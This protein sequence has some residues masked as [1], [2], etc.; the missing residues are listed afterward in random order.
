MFLSFNANVLEGKADGPFYTMKDLAEF[1]LHL[2]NAGTLPPYVEGG[3]S[4]LDAKMMRNLR[5][6]LKKMVRNVKTDKSYFDSSNTKFGMFL[7]E[8]S[9]PVF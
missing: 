3:L 8:A 9:E 5:P 2:S 7:L 4:E 6:S 1:F